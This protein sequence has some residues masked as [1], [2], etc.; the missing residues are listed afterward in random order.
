MLTCKH[1]DIDSVK[2]LCG[3]PLPCP[4]HTAIINAD[5][6]PPTIEIPVTATEALERRAILA[7]IGRL[8]SG[9]TP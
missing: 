2:L 1:T 3:H 8:I 6:S 9:D 4:Y 7:D 5:K